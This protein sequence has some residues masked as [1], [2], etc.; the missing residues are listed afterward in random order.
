MVA[1]SLEMNTSHLEAECYPPRM[2]TAS[3]SGAGIRGY[4]SKC[5]EHTGHLSVLSDGQSEVDNWSSA[6]GHR[7][8]VVP[9]AGLS[10]I[11]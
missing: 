4:I 10:F 6:Q 9:K 8:R 2:L 3:P 7:G 11:F 5:D 1:R